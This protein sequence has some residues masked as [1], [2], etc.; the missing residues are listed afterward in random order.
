MTA[1]A[2]P[3]YAAFDPAQLLRD[4]PLGQDFLQ[5][6]QG[7]GTD[8]LR[9]IQNQR[10]VQVLATA[11][12][13]PFYQRLWGGARLEPGDVRSLDDIGKL[14]VYDKS[15]LMD[16]VAAHPPLGDFHSPAGERWPMVLHTTSGTT[17][18]PQ[19]LIFGPKSREVQ[20]IL[21][22][23]A[24]RLQGLPPAAVVQS[25]YG[26]GMINGGHY[27]REAVLRYTDAV[28]LSA[29]TGVETPSVSQVRLMRDF[30]VNV[31]VG[32]AD[33]LK[34]LAEVA[35]AEGLEPGRD[36]RI[37][38]VSG[39][40]GMESRVL[41]GQMWGGARLYDWYGVGDT[42]AIAAE[43]PDQDGLHVWEDA[44]HLE[45]LHMD[46]GQP[47]DWRAGE[48]GDMVVTCLY[49]DDAF[50]VIRFNTHDLT[51]VLPGEGALR[52]PFRRIRGF[53]GRSDNMVKLRGINI[54]P[55]GVGA[56]LDGL[57]G[58]GGEYI[59]VVRHGEGGREEMLVRVEL[60]GDGAGG[61][62]GREDG[63]AE[64]YRA[65]LKQKIG[66]EVG[67]EF[68]G[69]GELAEQTQIHRRQKPIRLLDERGKG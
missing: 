30:G 67:V 8:E 16:S 4:Y 34:K 25:C 58:Y 51:S 36:I 31:L 41:L 18:R 24:Y 23:R 57:P 46:S 55:Q 1:P 7:M 48:S 62:A 53:G 59:C 11:W 6:F 47:V 66:I 50:P 37:D 12:R 40:L 38:M 2:S 45:L 39:H 33:Y 13:I 26:H 20:G 43:G 3:Y 68:A 21:L 15:D 52:L 69:P 27:V 49:K 42:G 56:M 10:F 19:P 28:F 61:G 17:G 65:V 35:R 54:F 14:P 29:G 9:A 32:F 22:A 64:R 63:L 44:Q 60:V 5:R